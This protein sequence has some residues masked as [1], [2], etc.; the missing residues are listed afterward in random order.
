MISCFKRILVIRGSEAVNGT[1]I[2]QFCVI[3]LNVLIK[4]QRHD[5]IIGAQ[6]VFS[7]VCHVL[8]WQGQPLE[9]IKCWRRGCGRNSLLTPEEERFWRDERESSMQS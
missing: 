5:G 2:M 7:H 3:P 1:K 9:A 8:S 6:T 4:G